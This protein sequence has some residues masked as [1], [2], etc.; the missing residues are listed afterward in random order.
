VAEFTLL[1][2][3]YARLLGRDGY[4]ASPNVVLI[5]DNGKR[6]LVDPGSN[7][8]LLKR[9]LT[10]RGLAPP[11]IDLIF[12]T[13]FHPDHILNIRLFPEVTA[14][15]GFSTYRGDRAVPHSSRF[16][17]GT[18]IEIIRTRG[19]SPGH[20][21]LLFD[22]S[23]G[24]FAVAGDIFAWFNDDEPRYDLASLINQPDPFAND[25]ATLKKT[26]QW[27]LEMADYIIPGHGEIF[28]SPCRRGD[29][30]A[31]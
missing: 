7:V 17:P 4:I 15:D 11:D 27:L 16:L 18:G 19:H 8:G 23:R 26:R 22:T 10:R 21:S 24:R 31:R 2:K 28:A 9:A 12:L 1:V 6:V 29:R 14:C 3:G 13:H 25:M 20:A 5:E 30:D